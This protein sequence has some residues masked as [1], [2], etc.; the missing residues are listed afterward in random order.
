MDFSRVLRGSTISTAACVAG[1]SM[2]LGSKVRQRNVIFSVLP[3]R[4]M[5]RELKKEK[6]RRG[7]V[8]RQTHG[9]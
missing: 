9:Y 7:K 2:G 3:T 1:V 8:C 6:I 5:G 4:K